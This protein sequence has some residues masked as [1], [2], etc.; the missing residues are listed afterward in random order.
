M[1]KQSLTTVVSAVLF[2][3]LAAVIAFVPVPFVTWSPGSTYDVLG[4]T[5]DG[6]AVDLQGA[7]TFPTDGKLLMTTVSVTKV[8]SRMSLSRAVMSYFQPD[9]DV[10]P[11]DA[12]YPPGKSSDEIKAN[13]VAMMDSSKNDAIVAALR[14]A[15]F[16]VT[17]MPMIEGVVAAGPSNGHLEPGDLI[18]RVDSQAVHSLEDVRG[19]VR[20]RQVGD[21]V[22]FDVLRNGSPVKATV[23]SISSTQ[24]RRVPAVGMTLA[25]GYRYAPTVSYHI[26]PSVVG[27]SAGLAFALAIYDKLTPG[28]M[29]AGR[30]VAATG[31]IRP[32]GE[33]ISVGG[34]REKI[35]GA[36]NSGAS[37]FLVPEKNCSEVPD[38]P[39]LKVVKVE[40]MSDAIES[41][42]KLAESE[43]AEVPAC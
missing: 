1:A 32:T 2:V 15:N 40:N 34:V 43:D 41:L 23:T 25:T 20:A 33:V 37:V 39:P 21:T 30:T 8:D 18:E 42:A 27:P 12:I 17:E 24:D 16:P 38:N 36:K 13:E 5:D 31:E 3:A 22:T 6:Q 19:L 11:R 26:D 9:R 7:K 10:L 4:Q 14:S 29:V 28:S 35:A